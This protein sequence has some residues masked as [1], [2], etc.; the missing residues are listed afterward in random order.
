[1]AFG[2]NV[3]NWRSFW[4]ACTLCLSSLC[5]YF[6]FLSFVSGH[7]DLVPF[8]PFPYWHTGNATGMNVKGAFYLRKSRV[9]E[10]C[11]WAQTSL[12]GRYPWSLDEPKWA[13]QSR[14][15]VRLLGGN[16]VFKLDPNDHE[17]ISSS[18]VERKKL[19]SKSSSSCIVSDLSPDETMPAKLRHMRYR[20]H[21]TVYFL[22]A[23][24]TLKTCR[25]FGYVARSPPQRHLRSAVYPGWLCTG[26]PSRDP[27]SCR[28][29]Q[30]LPC[31]SRAW[32]TEAWKLILSVRESASSWHVGAGG[33]CTRHFK[34]PTALLF[35]LRFS[36]SLDLT[37]PMKWK[38][39]WWSKSPP[40]QKVCLLIDFLQDPF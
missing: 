39:I 17:F 37:S 7:C 26:L 40:P 4:K 18:D 20:V 15:E 22:P 38:T 28:I 31:A 14:G 33:A 8:P 34:C 35:S 2:L 32:L 25:T 10:G 16:G 27:G 24:A 19:T 9:E 21:A 3:W 5:S 1:M 30:H 23:D 29:M 36:L 13:R 12:A 6:H 11:L